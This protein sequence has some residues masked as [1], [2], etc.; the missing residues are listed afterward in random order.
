MCVVNTTEIHPING[1]VQIRL[2]TIYK[3]ECVYF[4]ACAIYI[5]EMHRFSLYPL[6]LH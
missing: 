5:R 3:Y 6:M 2:T 4:Y 1:S